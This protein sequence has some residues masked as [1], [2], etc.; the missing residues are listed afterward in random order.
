MMARL[1]DLDAKVST[2]TSKGEAHSALC[3]FPLELQL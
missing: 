2:H 1:H 3:V